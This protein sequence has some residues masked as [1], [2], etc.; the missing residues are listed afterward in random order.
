VGASLD[1]ARAALQRVVDE[2]LDDGEPPCEL[3]WEGGAF[4][5]GETPADHPWVGTVRGAL[6][7]ELGA[8]APLAGVPWGADMRQFTAR[9]I[10][11]VMVG[12]AGIE[13][14]HAVDESVDVGQLVT[15]ARTMIRAVLRACAAAPG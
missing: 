2:A 10:P 15:V 6:A 12:T 4:A 9:G 7:D 13:L 5:P 14:A 11:T 1:E 3:T 8:E